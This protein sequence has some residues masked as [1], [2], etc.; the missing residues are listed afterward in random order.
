[1]RSIAV[2]L[3]LILG[4]CAADRTIP[5]RASGSFHPLQLAK[6]D[7]DRVTEA[8]QQE[9]FQNLSTSVHKFGNV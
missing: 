7:I 8:H 3:T 1:M 4:A 5:G 2:A 6:S 9:I